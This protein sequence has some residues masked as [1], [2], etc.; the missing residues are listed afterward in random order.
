M[1]VFLSC[2]KTKADKTCCAK[3]MYTSPLF[4][5]SYAYAKS[6]KPRKIYILSALYGL[7]EVDDVIDPYEK[8]LTGASV[9]ECKNWAY[10]VYKQLEAKN[11]DFGEEAIFLCGDKYR[12]YLMPKFEKAT[13][14]LEGVSFGN[15]L[16][17]YKSKGM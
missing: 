10:K 9:T 3:D 17:F 14:P 1:I 12:K 5:K 7:L 2:V 8:T 6:L 11:T 15:Q 4:K 16:S 13:A